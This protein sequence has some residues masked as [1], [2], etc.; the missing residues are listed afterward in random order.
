MKLFWVITVTAFWTILNVTGCSG[1]TPGSVSIPRK[2]LLK[3]EYKSLG[4]SVAQI[5]V[6]EV[7]GH[8]K[9]YRNGE[10]YFVN[11]VG[12]WQ[13]RDYLL[14]SGGNSIRT[15]GIDE[16][17]IP[18]LDSCAKEGITV[19]VGLWVDHERHLIEA[20]NARKIIRL[21]YKKITGTQVE[22]VTDIALIKETLLKNK[23]SFA[24]YIVDDI[25]KIK[26]HDDLDTTIGYNNDAWFAERFEFY[27]KQ[28]LS[29]KD[30]PALLMWGIGNEVQ[31]NHYLDK[32]DNIQKSFDLNPRVWQQIG[33]LAT[34]IKKVD[35]NHPTS[36]ILYWPESDAIE[37]IKKY[38][39]DID[40][41]GLNAYAGISVV[42]RDAVNNGWSGP[43]IVTEYGPD[44]HWE[45]GKTEWGAYIEDNSTTKATKYKKRTQQ[46]HREGSCLGGYAFLWGEKQERTRTWYGLIFN[47]S[48]V[49]AGADALAKVWT[50]KYPK[51]RAPI[52]RT[53]K[54]DNRY[55]KDNIRFSKGA[56]YTGKLDAVD[57][58]DKRNL[59]YVYELLR[60]SQSK[61]IGGEEEDVPETIVGAISAVNEDGT[62]EIEVPKDKGPYRLFAY[63]YDQNGKMGHA[64]FPF[65]VE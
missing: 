28:I 20:V 33:R 42:F 32:A 53:L 25:K 51:N 57:T 37:G 3:G 45:V 34:F 63:V 13:Q 49:T 44:G 62:F 29:I 60:E 27:K 30:H 1:T 8:W 10:E 40:V 52:V 16:H 24:Q 22:T 26:S 9:L 54:I 19:H 23:S 4:N 11:G 36:T 17:T 61:K 56:S 46:L 58:E 65:F 48:D 55:A 15:W 39:K 7:D 21:A 38:A 31:T 35:G 14:A 41:L 50:G 5:E 18:L 47:G 59:V 2:P 12:G 6:K 64:S 43:T